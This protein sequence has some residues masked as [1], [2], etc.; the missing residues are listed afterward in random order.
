MGSAGY[1]KIYG[2]SI[3]NNVQLSKSALRRLRRK[4]ESSSAAVSVS[5]TTS[6]ESENLKSA[7]LTLVNETSPNISNQS[8][9]SEY[10]NLVIQ[11]PTAETEPQK[12]AVELVHPF[13]PFS[14]S[15]AD[16]GLISGHKSETTPEQTLDLGNG[17][18]DKSAHIS[19]RNLR[20][21][22]VGIIGRSAIENSDAPKAA[23]LNNNH[24][25]P[26]THG[27]SLKEAPADKNFLLSLLLDDGE[28]SP[29]KETICQPISKAEDHEG[30]KPAA[31]LSE[32]SVISASFKQ[33]VGANN[34]SGYSRKSAPTTEGYYKSKNGSVNIRL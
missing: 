13:S 29:S 24:F 21:A 33:S 8:L 19:V 5:A 27:P 23:S 2:E 16:F 30:Y 14:K 7:A 20:S 3:A 1:S 32:S 17:N 18:A 26:S 12:G 10:Q 9:I 4:Q 31:T 25:F 11:Q 34:N 22:K 28:K 6:D 15:N